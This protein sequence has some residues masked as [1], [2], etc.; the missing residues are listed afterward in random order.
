MNL[1]LW[2]TGMDQHLW[3]DIGFC[4]GNEH[5]K[6]ILMWEGYHM[7]DFDGFSSGMYLINVGGY[8]F[9]LFHPQKG[10]WL[11]FD[12]RNFEAFVAQPRRKMVFG[13]DMAIKGHSTH[14]GR[15]WKEVEPQYIAMFIGKKTEMPQTTG[16]SHYPIFRLQICSPLGFELQYKGP[17]PFTTVAVSERRGD[18]RCSGMG[19]VGVGTGWLMRRWFSCWN[20]AWSEDMIATCPVILYIKEIWCVVYDVVHSPGLWARAVSSCVPFLWLT[21]NQQVSLESRTPTMTGD[22]L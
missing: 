1:V 7:W 12:W 17:G 6:A 2:N 21:K 18:L 9:F 19:K 14:R 10:W 13:T 8:S 5:L 20:D 4:W 16:T 15:V 11:S 22:A 3:R